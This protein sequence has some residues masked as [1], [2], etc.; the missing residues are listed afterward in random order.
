MGVKTI[1]T[2]FQKKLLYEKFEKTIVTIFQKNLLYEKFGKTIIR[3]FQ[4][5]LLCEMK[6]TIAIFQKLY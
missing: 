1:A 2:I 5:N 4:K 3:I 6:I